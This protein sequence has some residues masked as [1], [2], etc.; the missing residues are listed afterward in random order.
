MAPPIT[1]VKPNSHFCW[2]GSRSHT[3]TA[4]TMLRKTAYCATAEINEFTD[5]DRLTQQ[6]ERAA[7]RST[8]RKRVMVTGV[9]GQQHRGQSR[10][11]LLRSADHGQAVHAR[12]GEV[13][14][15][16]VHLFPHGKQGERL[17]AARGDQHPEALILQLLRQQPPHQDLVVDQQQPHGR[18]CLGGPGH[19]CTRYIRRCR[20]AGAHLGASLRQ[21]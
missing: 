15:D 21:P 9:A 18:R 19:S 17:G 10:T 13:G 8:H 4:I 11:E 6:R 14:D 16:G 3:P 1:P 5:A 12:H 20:R 7:D 2:R